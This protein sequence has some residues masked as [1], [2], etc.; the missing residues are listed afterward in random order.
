VTGGGAGR[1]VTALLLAV[2]AALV[3]VQL[4]DPWGDEPHGPGPYP[5]VPVSADG[6]LVGVTTL[7]LARNSADPWTARDLREVDDFEQR[8]RRHADVVMWFADWERGRFDAHQAAAV[9]RRGS[10]PEVSWEPWDSRI[11]PGRPQ[12]R[13]RLSRILAGDFDR[14][15]R[16]FAVAVRRYAHPVRLRFAQEMNGRLYPWAERVNGNRP[17]E[18]ARAWRHVHRIFDRAGARNV[19]WIWSPVVGGLRAAQYPG[20]RWVDVVGVAGF[21]GGTATFAKRWRPFRPTFDPSLDALEQ[22]A[23]GKPLALPEIASAEQGGDK[24]AWIAD[25][26]TAADERRRM[27]EIVWFDV[28]KEAD[29]R[30]S[31]SPAAQAAFA[32]GVARLR[33]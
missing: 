26:L 31:S 18:F 32:R 4:L 6:V 22:L 21:N 2:I 10:L 11:A 23:P 29:W 8:A 16:R 28:D 30:I 15:V 9:R 7:S 5:A 19:T 24:A 12:P 1:A 33:R 17:G 25:M 20:D 13:Y 14:V 27:R 3:A